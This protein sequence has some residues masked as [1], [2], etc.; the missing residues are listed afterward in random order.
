MNSSEAAPASDV[1]FHLTRTFNAPRALVF[2]TMTETA[3]LHHWWGPKEC[4]IE[5]AT[6]DPKPGGMF[7]YCMRF[8]GG[9]AMWGRWIYREIEAPE[10][11]VYVNGFADAEGNAAPNPMDANWPMEMLITITLIEQDGKT[12]LNLLSHPIN[13][14]E[15]ERQTFKAGHESMQGGFGGM[16]DR[17]EEYLSLLVQG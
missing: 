9:F 10:R 2:K 13:A 16:Y 5:V 11:I 8:P 6:H 1:D 7:H 4:R 3:H 15:S 14:T 17:Y 12:V